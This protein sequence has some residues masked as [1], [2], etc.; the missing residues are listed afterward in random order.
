MEVFFIRVLEFT[1][2]GTKMPLLGEF[3]Q[4]RNLRIYFL[5]FKLLPVIIFFSAL[6]FYLILF[7]CH[8]KRLYGSSEAWGLTRIFKISGAESLS[9]AEID[10]LGQNRSTFTYQS[11]LGKNESSQKY[12]LLWWGARQ[13]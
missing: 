3:W 5:F 13:L 1:G 10:N 8:A 4:C 7:W 2:E 11:L 12:F 6:N 9:V